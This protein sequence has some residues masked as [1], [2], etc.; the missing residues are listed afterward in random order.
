MAIGAIR[1]GNADRKISA[2]YSAP[3]PGSKTFKG[4]TC[5]IAAIEKWPGQKRANERAA[6]AN[7]SARYGDNDFRLGEG[8]NRLQWKE[9]EKKILAR[10]KIHVKGNGT[11]NSYLT[12]QRGKS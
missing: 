12:V 6:A 3:G 8:S 10:E 11:N 4:R 9:K 7:Q 1:R 2:S 5:E